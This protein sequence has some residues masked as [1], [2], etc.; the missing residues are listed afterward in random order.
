MMTTTDTETRIYVACLAAYNN[1]KLHGRWIDA[2]QG[3]D[4]IWEEI[5]AMLKASPEPGAEEHAI[6]DYEGFYGIRLSEYESIER[7]AEIA[8]IIEEHGPAFAY[9][10]NYVGGD[11]SA[12]DFEEAYRGEWESEEAFAEE[13]VNE[14][15]WEG[16]P[17]RLEIPSGPYGQTREVNIFEELGGAIDM[18]YIARKLFMGDYFSADGDGVTYVF[19]SH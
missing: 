6:H 3:A 4:E 8:A 10:A 5:R 19:S 17:A 1:G 12:E 14:M 9:Y 11:P 13:H 18:E 7:V 2:T 16:I 15:G